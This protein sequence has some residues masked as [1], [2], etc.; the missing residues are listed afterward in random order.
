MASISPEQMA[1][2]IGNILQTFNHTVETLVDQAALET[3]KA[4]AYILQ[5]YSPKR[6][7]RYAR[8]WTYKKTKK[9]T[10]YIHNS[11]NYRLTHLL[12]KGHK[13]NFKT[14][15]YGTKKS[16]APIPH[17][18]IVEQKV[19]HDFEWRVAHAIEYQK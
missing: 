18:S 10:V 15:K 14:G 2:E 6:T 8:T 7:G 1:T 13:T 4:G 3:G 11:K 16:T 19:A 17:I 9:G 12:E 5:G